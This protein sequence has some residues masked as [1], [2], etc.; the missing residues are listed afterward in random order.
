M[1]Y[2]ELVGLVLGQFV[3][4]PLYLY[5]S[6]LCSWCVY[7]VP[8]PLLS[9]LVF[10]RLYAAVDSGGAWLHKTQLLT[11]LWIHMIT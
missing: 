10:S 7:K 6:N 9:I 2:R 4:L 5:C 1:S 8:A 3:F 11:G